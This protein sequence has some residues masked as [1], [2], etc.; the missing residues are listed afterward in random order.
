MGFSASQTEAI[1]HRDGP[2]MVLAGP[3]SGKTLVITNRVKALIESGVDSGQI[4]VITFTRAAAR[5]MRE[6]FERLMEGAAH[7]VTFG[8]FHAVFFQ[9]LKVA[10]HYDSSS[11]LREEDRYQIL[12]SLA[13]AHH[14]EPDD[15]KETISA[16]AQEISRVKNDQ[17]PLEHYY[18]TSCPEE[19]F[20]K[21]Y[22]E[23]NQELSRRRRIDFDDMLLYTWD[24]LTQRPDILA[25]WQQRFGYILVDEF[26]DINYLQYRIVQLLAQ[27]QD[28]LFIVGDDDQSIY[29]FRGARPQ[30]MLGF[31]K[32]YPQ[33]GTII[34][35]ENYRSARPIVELAG[36]MIRENTA[37]FDKPVVCTHPQGDPVEIRELPDVESQ[38]LFILRQIQQ[39]HEAGMEYREMA[40]LTRTNTGGGY[41]AE[42]LG[43]FGIP[44]AMR[45]RAPLLYDHWIAEDLF[46][47]IRLGAGE[48]S[49]QD[50]LRIMNRPL[51]YL[52]RSCVD[53]PQ[54][55]FERL[56]LWYEDKR[57]M[58]ERID[59]L[60]RD[61][62][63]IGGMRPY[64]AVNY[65]RQGIGY[66][67]FLEEYAQ[68]HRIEPEPLLEIAD[69]LQGRAKPF[70]SFQEWSAQVAKSREQMKE[71]GKTLPGGADGVVLSTMH[72]AK[73]LEFDEVYLPDLNEGV[74]PHKKAALS[75]DLEEERRLLYVG[76]TRARSRLHLYYLKE[77]FGKKQQVSR[78]I[79][80][81]LSGAYCPE[82]SS[83]D[84]S[85]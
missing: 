69:E 67:R 80:P 73:G 11:I 83:S 28:N 29:H 70:A 31:T 61:L 77:R 1:R 58:I 23:Y 65:I 3:G 41:L 82:P 62:Q 43:R 68:T 24:L 40:I 8:T 34:L 35:R 51:R 64:A 17:I 50:L 13:Y 55:D 48:R 27:P 47:Y 44:Y 12:T 5:E 18:A 49:R 75:T 76:M 20:R 79:E 42:Q 54:A 7:R 25:A 22:R 2:A 53:T 4:L 9:I 56:R 71:S 52:S 33:A 84:S 6:R 66:D 85:S 19:M 60:E 14:L 16:I 32:D 74:V 57:W 26:Q 72:A 10:Y 45:E 30:I 15:V 37:R 36:R 63:L 46:A 59:D 81:L 21:I 78:F 39:A 38:A